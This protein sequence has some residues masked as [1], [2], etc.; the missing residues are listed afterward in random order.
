MRVS[1]VGLE[2]VSQEQL[3]AFRPVG[4]MKEP[5]LRLAHAGTNKPWPRWRSN[6]A[7]RGWPAVCQYCADKYLYSCEMH[8]AMSRNKDRRPTSSNSARHLFKMGH[9]FLD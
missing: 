5:G 1:R 9:K 7:A 8:P 3:N 4:G 2:T 6:R